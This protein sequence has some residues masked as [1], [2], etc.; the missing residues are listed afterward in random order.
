MYHEKIDKTLLS[1]YFKN[2]KLCIISKIKNFFG[3]KI[4]LYIFFFLQLFI[5]E[6]FS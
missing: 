4:F 1:I 6:L 3:N 2:N 5:I